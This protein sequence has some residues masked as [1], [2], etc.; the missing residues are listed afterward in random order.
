MKR[1]PGWKQL[2][3]APVRELRWRVKDEWDVLR[4]KRDRFD[5]PARF[6]FPGHGDFREIGRQFFDL[7]VRFGGLEPDDRVLEIGCGTGRMALPLTGYL[8]GGGGYDGID[9][10]GPSI[11]WCRSALSRRFSNFRFQHADV[12]NREY[13]PSGRVAAGEYTLPFED[14]RFDFVFLTSVFTHMLPPEIRRYLAEISRVLAPGG[15]LLATF[16]LTPET[17]GV[18]L[19]MRF[20]HVRDGYRTVNLDVPEQAVAVSEYDVRSW[21]AAAGLK[22]VEPVHRGAW[23]GIENAPTFQDLIVAK[24]GRP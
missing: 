19:A 12:F 23:S 11:R 16:F 13:N 18:A 4:G 8:K 1:R 20:D 6:G 9:V 2:I 10:S 22:I 5:P 3:P 7:F 14:R 17:N 15:A 21:Y 24:K